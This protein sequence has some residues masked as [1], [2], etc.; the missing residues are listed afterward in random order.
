M[1]RSTHNSDYI[2]ND[3]WNFSLDDIIK[4]DLK[5][6]IEY[7]KAI[8]QNEKI[9]YIGHSQ[10]T[11]MFF[12]GYTLYPEFLESSVEK[13]IAI[14]PAFSDFYSNS[15]YIKFFQLTGILD[16]LYSIDVGNV[17]VIGTTFHDFIYSICSKLTSICAAIVDNIVSIVPTHR[18]KGE[19]ILEAFNYEPG[20]TSVKNL[21]QWIQIHKTRQHAYFDYGKVKNIDVY[22]TEQPPLYDLTKFS[23]FTIKSFLT[24]SDNDGLITPQDTQDFLNLI[25][26]GRRSELITIKNLTNYNHLDYV[27]SEDASKDI[28][29]DVMSFIKVDA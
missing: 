15:P 20:G 21:L 2:S 23:N 8:T 5:A 9:I 24:N 27:W 1:D 11:F 10:G 28:F 6:N 4:Y 7:V 19:K 26:Q 18:M 12:M 14:G 16:F 25:P 3:Y 17:L 22:G 29:E 13:F